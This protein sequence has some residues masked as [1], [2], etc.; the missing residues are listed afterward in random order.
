MYTHRGGAPTAYAPFPTP[1]DGSEQ[2]GL[3][4]RRTPFDAVL[5]DALRRAPG[6]T[7]VEG[8]R[9]TGVLRSASGTV[10]GVSTDGGPV[11]ASVVIAADGLH[12]PLRAAAGWTGA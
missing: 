3:G 11:L 2:W 1:A 10:T 7:F 6:V 4:V 9:A 12:S 8:V 5:V